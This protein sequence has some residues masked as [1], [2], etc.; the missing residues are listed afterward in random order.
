MTKKYIC[1]DCAK[2]RVMDDPAGNV[3]RMPRNDEHTADYA[4]TICPECMEK[5]KETEEP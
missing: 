5:K 1:I 2:V 3:W 4:R